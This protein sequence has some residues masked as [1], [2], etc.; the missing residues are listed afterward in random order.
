M[1]T[2]IPEAK[3]RIMANHV[4]ALKRAR[5]TV[6]R[7]ATNRAN[8][9][10]VRTSLRS[11]R[12]AIASGDLK[13]AQAQFRVTVSALDKSVQKGVFHKNTV[14]RYKSRLNSRLKA[15]AAKAA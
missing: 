5:Q 6:T 14:S 3:D 2:R 10:R 7:T 11:L 15:L 9:S 12:E 4:S 1:L 8:R 13:Q